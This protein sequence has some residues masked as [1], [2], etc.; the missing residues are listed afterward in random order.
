M[1]CR[2]AG[3]GPSGNTHRPRLRAQGSG[4]VGSP[5]ERSVHP[6]HQRGGRCRG[7]QGPCPS[8]LTEVSSAWLLW[9]SRAP[10]KGPTSWGRCCVFEEP[11]GHTPHL[12][13]PTWSAHMPAPVLGSQSQREPTRR[14]TGVHG[15][16]VSPKDRSFLRPPVRAGEATLLSLSPEDVR[17]GN[18]GD[19]R[20][21]SRSVPEAGPLG[22]SC[23]AIP[24]PGRKGSE[25]G[26]E[27]WSQIQAALDPAQLQEA[28]GGLPWARGG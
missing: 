2:G 28:P 5:R 21:A 1:L 20:A 9:E 4:A 18:E 13:F 27:G 25:A 6:G 15:W 26:R 10:S 19:P 22:R 7:Q 14:E 17:V 8:R 23:P 12:S 16:T 3:L 11:A 24:S